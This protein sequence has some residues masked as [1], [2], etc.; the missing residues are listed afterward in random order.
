MDLI[1]MLD[2]MLT[3]ATPVTTVVEKLSCEDVADEDVADGDA[4]GRHEAAQEAAAFMEASEAEEAAAVSPETLVVDMTDAQVDAVIAE[5]ETAK[6]EPGFVNIPPEMA[7]AHKGMRHQLV[8]EGVC[9]HCA[10]CG[11]PL[12]DAVSTQRGIGPICSKKGYHDEVVA[13]DDTEALLALAEF[14]VLVDYLVKKYKP[15]GNRALCNGLVRTASLNR[16]TQVHAAC[17]DAVEALGFTRLA[18]ALRESISIVEISDEPGK[19]ELYSLWVKKSDF[20]WAFWNELK[21]LPG[22]FMTRYPKKHTVVPKV[23]RRQLAK[24][25]LAH[26]EG[27]CV[28]TPKG[29]FKITPDWFAKSNPAPVAPAAETG[30]A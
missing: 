6:A 19:P 28:K 5:R 11:Q 17:C 15:E 24:L 9:T 26:Y 3:P 2:E 25:L 29:A 18:A 21:R 12:T 14:P 13:S 27:L 7:Y 23:L 10:H 30:A 16:R 20:S 22:V 1:K 4:F 8:F